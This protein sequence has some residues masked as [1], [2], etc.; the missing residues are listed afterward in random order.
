MQTNELNEIREK[1]INPTVKF[2]AGADG[3]NSIDTIK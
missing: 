1:I 3:W 2:V